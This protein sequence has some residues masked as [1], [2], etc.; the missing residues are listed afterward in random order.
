LNWVSHEVELGGSQCDLDVVSGAIS[1]LRADQD[2][3]GACRLGSYIDT[4]QVV[5][6]RPNPGA[7]DGYYYL[8]NGTCAQSIGYGNSS[9]GPRTGLP[10][11]PRCR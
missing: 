7:G 8:V 9:A 4:T 2:F 6:T 11:G 5:D 3:S 1:E 10:P